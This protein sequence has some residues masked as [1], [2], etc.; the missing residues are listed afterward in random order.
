ML[1]V[2]HN[3]NSSVTSNCVSL[4]KPIIIIITIIIIIS[5]GQKTI[6]NGPF[7][8]WHHL[9]LRPESS[10]VFL[11]CAN[12]GFCHLNLAGITK[13]KYEKKNEKDSGRSSKMTPSCKWPIANLGISRR[14]INLSLTLLLGKEVPVNFLKGAPPVRLAPAGSGLS[15]CDLAWGCMLMESWPPILV[16]VWTVC[17]WRGS[18][19]GLEK[20]FPSISLG[21]G[22]GIFDLREL[23]WQRKKSVNNGCSLF[24]SEINHTIP[25][26]LRKSKELRR[27]RYSFQK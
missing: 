6:Q 19:G 8:R 22:S 27:P 12:Y 20:G 15:L 21:I 13:F 14:L 9:I 24:S 11:S 1:F 23:E 2:G 3:V 25:P 4:I 5:D 16:L 17:G 26:S 18:V 7:T 10:R